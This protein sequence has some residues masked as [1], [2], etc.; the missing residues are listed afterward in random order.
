[1]VQNHLFVIMVSWRRSEAEKLRRPVI[2]GRERS[3]VLTLTI[4][5]PAGF[6]RCNRNEGNGWRRPTCAEQAMPRIGG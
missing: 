1:M 4:K 2:R 5:G 3:D 6:D